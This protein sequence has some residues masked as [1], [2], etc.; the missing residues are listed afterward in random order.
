M[1]FKPLDLNT[2]EG[3][4]EPLETKP[5][6][7]SFTPIS[8][9][10]TI[11]V[12]TK[13]L[14]GIKSFSDIMNISD[15][16]KSFFESALDLSKSLK[17]GKPIEAGKAAVELVTYPS[18]AV[19]GATTSLMKAIPALS[20][21]YLEEGKMR[22]GELQ[23]SSLGDSVQGKVR[24]AQFITS[25]PV[26]AAVELGMNYR[27]AL[28][29]ALSR[30]PDKMLASGLRAIGRGVL[31]DLSDEKIVG[32]I[33]KAS[34]E[35]WQRF[36]DYVWYQPEFF[37]LDILAAGGFGLHALNQGGYLSKTLAKT[38]WAV[39]RPFTHEYAP[40][41]PLGKLG[42][43]DDLRT[44]KGTYA[45]EIAGARAA[46][47]QQLGAE[48]IFQTPKQAA[49]V[50][51]GG[52]VQSPLIYH[53]GMT[54]GI[55]KQ[56][57]MNLIREARKTQ[58]FKKAK[59]MADSLVSNG[60]IGPDELK[61]AL[62]LGKVQ[63]KIRASEASL[64]ELYPDVGS[65]TRANAKG[66]EYWH[67]SY[68]LYESKWKPSKADLNVVRHHLASKGYSAS[69]IKGVLENTIKHKE[70]PILAGPVRTTRASRAL[71]GRAEID[72]VIRKHLLGEIDDAPKLI[73]DTYKDQSE[74]LI[75][76]KVFDK[77]SKDPNI[78]APVGTKARAGFVRVEGK[79]FG[80]LNGRLIKKEL[81]EEFVSTIKDVPL[82]ER[83]WQDVYSQWK[84]WK[85]VYNPGGH[86][87][88][89]QW[90]MILMAQTGTGPD[91]VL[92]AA[93]VLKNKTPLYYKMLKHKIIR[94]DFAS[95]ET[96]LS[97]I[98]DLQKGNSWSKT[99]AKLPTTLT[100]LWQYPDDMLKAAYA[101]KRMRKGDS[102]VNAAKMA[103]RHL[104]YYDELPP[105]TKMLKSTVMPFATFTSETLRATVLNAAMDF[106]VTTA[107][108]AE[109]PRMVNTWQKKSLGV[110]DEEWKKLTK[111]L[112][113]YL[114]DGTYVLLDK[115]GS[116]YYLLNTTYMSGIGNITSLLPRPQRTLGENVQ[117]WISSPAISI[118]AALAYGKGAFGKD[119]EGAVEKVLPKEFAK[120]TALQLGKSAVPAVTPWIGTWWD[121]VKK[122]IKG[123][124]A[125]GIAELEL[126]GVKITEFD[127]KEAERWVSYDRARRKKEI[128]D[129]IRRVKNDIKYG[130]RTKEEGR[131]L[132]KQINER[133]R[134]H[135]EGF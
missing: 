93:K 89:V 60:L 77:W 67:R 122:Q 44:L 68:K 72:P 41:A 19:V 90:D 94:T 104:P 45:S 17:E 119:I 63:A 5:F 38:P 79:S 42:V 76:G 106:P 99:V 88:N 29:G 31:A 3:S 97:F 20:Q 121:K 64:R 16:K 12:P 81:A 22:T 82:W 108:L 130:K 23:I 37:A 2:G 40:S 132:I 49:L 34:K 117:N 65:L 71:K 32:T 8:E 100:D 84:A 50:S 103:R 28:T 123:E 66:G 24:Q 116:K 124:V 120:Q 115:E 113:N 107:L 126:A 33:R 114:Q 129:A 91:D 57:M 46:K 135:I 131:A 83:A 92:R 111:L 112:P 62:Y 105:V 58:G 1:I 47:A 35:D 4:F 9:E 128:T 21:R 118:P 70:L 73:Y 134:K 75:K 85:T 27:W 54:T 6:G 59:V 56:G 48:Q 13:G 36:K 86:G 127:M 61:Q 98:K 52:L 15:N 11:D 96:A 109:L 101:I 43:A 102:I 55:S 74:L 18:L 95:S 78:V 133:K 7:S 30:L 51:K 10:D 14:W 80:K 87:R 53:T 110:S 26:M 39:R 125:P 25:I 69:E